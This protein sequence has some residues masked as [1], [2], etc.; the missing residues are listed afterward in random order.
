[1]KKIS[2]ILIFILTCSSIIAQVQVK[3][4]GKVHYTVIPSNEF[5]SHRNDSIAKAMN[6][7]IQQNAAKNFPDVL[8]YIL[9]SNP[10]S[11]LTNFQEVLVYYQKYQ[12]EFFNQYDNYYGYS[13]E[14]MGINL[15][16]FK[17]HYQ[18]GMDAIKYAVDNFRKLKKKEKRLS[19][20]KKNDILTDEELKS[21]ELPL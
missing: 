20:K 5:V 21:F 15:S 1:M 17:N 11:E 8:L 19:K 9:D 3:Q 7:Y 12:G 16:L 6:D 4:I 14:H 2:L 10:N 18:K 13:K